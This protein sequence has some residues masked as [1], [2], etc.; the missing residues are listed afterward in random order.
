MAARIHI[1]AVGEIFNH[2]DVRRQCCTG[3]DAFEQIMA[4]HRVFRHPA[5]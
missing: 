5:R 4:E 3:K 2:L 1:M